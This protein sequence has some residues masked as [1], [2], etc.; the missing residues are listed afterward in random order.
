[1]AIDGANKAIPARMLRKARLSMIP[2][3]SIDA[4]CLKAGFCQPERS[5]HR[6]DG[7]LPNPETVCL[8]MIRNS[9]VL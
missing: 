5:R 6:S 2:L 3:P 1:V 7:G 9:T 8:I 4:L